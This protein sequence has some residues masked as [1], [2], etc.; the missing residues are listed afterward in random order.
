LDPPDAVVSKP[1]RRDE[2]DT[3][4][5]ALPGGSRMK[6]KGAATPA[7][8]GS[9]DDLGR[10]GLRG[11]LIVQC[12]VSGARISLNGRS[13]TRWVTPYLFS[14]VPGAYTVTISK[15][16]YLNWT[17]RVQVEAG[18]KDWVLAELAD[19]GTG[20]LTVETEPSGMRVYIDGRP[21]GVSRVDTVLGAGWHTCEV[22]PP[23]GVKPVVGK[24]HLDAGE[25]LTKR[26]RV[27]TITT[28]AGS[29]RTGPISHPSTLSPQ[30]E[31]LE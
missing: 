16:G 24:F 29:A 17:R 2:A 30:G 27:K 15:N 26:I 4:D 12:G 10:R 22:I 19:E 6:G 28:A 1:W 5:A 18:K 8:R 31:R 3:R 7:H 14:L 23:S 25:S 11:E 13:D 9:F 21:Y 20:I